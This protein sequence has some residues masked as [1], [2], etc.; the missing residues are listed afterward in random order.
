MAV[1]EEL[2][3]YQNNKPCPACGGTRLREEARHVM[4][5]G[6]PIYEVSAMPLKQT[7]AFF[8]QLSVEGH[9]AKVADKIVQEVIARVGFLNNVG[10]DYLRSTATPTRSPA[11]SRNASASLH[12]SAPASPA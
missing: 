7:L 2:S 4:V 6:L 8:S 1:R 9:R 12:K 5:G 10:L 3:K 11:A